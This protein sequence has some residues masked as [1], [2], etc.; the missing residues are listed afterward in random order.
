M[1]EIAPHPY[2]FSRIYIDHPPFPYEYN[3]GVNSRGMYRI[4]A[5]HIAKLIPHPRQDTFKRIQISA[6]MHPFPLSP[7]LFPLANLTP[8]A[9]IELTYTK[10]I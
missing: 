9:A 7:S 2:T 5:H 3:I 10:N 4:R 8:A 6:S 1:G